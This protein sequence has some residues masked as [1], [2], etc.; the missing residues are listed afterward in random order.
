MVVTA[1]QVN[2]GAKVGQ[3]CCS[4]QI[5]TWAQAVPPQ[6]ALALLSEVKDT[7]WLECKLGFKGHKVLPSHRSGSQQE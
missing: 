5:E 3:A 7:G 6:V 4:A 2:M 1:T